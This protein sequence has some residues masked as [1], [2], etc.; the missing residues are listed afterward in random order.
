MRNATGIL[1]VS[2]AI[3]WAPAVSAAEPPTAPTPSSTETS[4]AAEF[5]ETR[6]RPLLAENCFSCH[7]ATRPKAGLRLDSAAAL[8]KGSDA[9]PVLVSG[10]PDNSPLIQA[11]R[12]DGSVRMPPKGKLPAQAIETLT[13]WVKMGAPW[14][15]TTAANVVPA[16]PAAAAAWRKHWAFQ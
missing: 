3:G 15:E 9:G 6:V 2:L 13:T 10:D 5:F 12:Y 4:S 7:G 1:A 8:R 16:R 14:P 11:I